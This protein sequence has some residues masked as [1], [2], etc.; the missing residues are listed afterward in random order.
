MHFR[1]YTHTQV[2]E[3]E[4]EIKKIKEDIGRGERERELG[5]LGKPFL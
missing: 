1:L 5:K 2:Q 3:I 4:K